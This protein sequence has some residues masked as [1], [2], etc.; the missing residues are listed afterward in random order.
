MQSTDAAGSTLTVMDLKTKKPVTVKLT[1]ESQF[2]KLPPMVGQMIA[3]RMSGNGAASTGAP[4][5]GSSGN[6]G[7]NPKRELPIPAPG[8]AVAQPAQS[9]MGGVRLARAVALEAVIFSKC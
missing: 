4:A 6:T 3:M 5:N 8:L 7:A 9:G 1:P 2:R